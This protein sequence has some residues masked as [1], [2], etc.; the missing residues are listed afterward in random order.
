METKTEQHTP[1][2]WYSTASSKAGVVYSAL[3]NELIVPYARTGATESTHA[4]AEFIVR[5]CNSHEALLEACKMT[6]AVVIPDQD[7]VIMFATIEKVRAAIN[8]AKKEQ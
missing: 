2:P 5:A 7:P 8:K 6:V 4:N 1:V 3:N